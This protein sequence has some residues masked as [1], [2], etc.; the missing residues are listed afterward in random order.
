MEQNAI[1]EDRKWQEEAEMHEHHAH[2]EVQALL[3][4]ERYEFQMAEAHA[5]RQA[6]EEQDCQ[7]RELCLQRT[8]AEA[9]QVLREMRESFAELQSV[10]AIAVSKIQLL[11]QTSARHMEELQICEGRLELWQNDASREELEQ[12]RTCDLQRLE[13]M[14]E[15]AALV[16]AVGAK[17]Q[18][19]SEL[20]KQKEH[21]RIEQREARE[22]LLASMKYS[23]LQGNEMMSLEESQA[24]SKLSSERRAVE[25]EDARLHAEIEM[26]SLRHEFQEWMDD[27]YKKCRRWRQDLKHAVWTLRGQQGQLDLHEPWS[28]LGSELDSISSPEQSCLSFRNTLRGPESDVAEQLL[29]LWQEVRAAAREHS[30]QSCKCGGLQEL[31]VFGTTFVV[32]PSNG[33]NVEPCA[34]LGRMNSIQ[35]H[36][37]QE[38]QQYEDDLSASWFDTKLAVSDFQT[39]VASFC[40]E[41]KFLDAEKLKTRG[42][43]LLESIV[44]CQKVVDQP[45]VEESPLAAASAVTW[46]LTAIALQ[47]GEGFDEGTFVVHG[48]G[49][50]LIFFMLLPHLKGRYSSHFYNRAIALSIEDVPEGLATDSL[51]DAARANQGWQHFGIDVPPDGSNNLP[52]NKQT[53]V[54]GRIRMPDDSVGVYIKPEGHGCDITNPLE[55]ISHGMDYVKSQA[56]RRLGDRRAHDEGEH[57]RKEYVPEQIETEFKDLKDHINSMSSASYFDQERLENFGLSEM[58]KILRAQCSSLSDAKT[59]AQ[60]LLEYLERTYGSSIDARRGREVLIHTSE[61]RASSAPQADASD[62]SSANA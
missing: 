33:S 40:C 15:N 43:A 62:S 20:S 13:L 28:E 37:A 24:L 52:A 50:D 31:A 4:V 29:C 17:M 41:F 30:G 18:S 10:E 8:H 16:V 9:L 55:M 49:A 1:Q 12:R 21:A 32:S 54:L 38:D 56:L 2:Q 36:N 61:L 22:E 23:R 46:A 47:H 14:S 25:L 51:K 6:Q 58:A 44:D 7:N 39:Y 26:Q 34:G 27:D 19:D 59:R 35:N 57:K 3:Q 45:I 60:K 5:A 53:L 48:P 11:E 42:L